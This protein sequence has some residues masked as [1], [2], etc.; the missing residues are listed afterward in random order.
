MNPPT[1]ASPSSP[2]SFFQGDPGS[3]IPCPFMGPL[4][5]RFHLCSVLSAAGAQTVTRAQ[6]GSGGLRLYSLPAPGTSW[7]WRV[8][9]PT[10]CHW[11][12]YCGNRSE[13]GYQA[14]PR[15]AGDVLLCGA[16]ALGHLP[17]LYRAPVSQIHAGPVASCG[18]HKPVL[19]Y[20]RSESLDLLLGNTRG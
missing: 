16:C 9:S 7:V 3:R 15:L 8:C 18:G 20:H 6:A 17:E 12:F 4:L 10:W 5:T 11:R 2:S 1:N 14:P 13:R 19:P